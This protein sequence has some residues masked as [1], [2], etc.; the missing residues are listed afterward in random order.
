M[1]MGAVYFSA[2]AVGSLPSVVYY[3]VVPTGA[4]IVSEKLLS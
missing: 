1:L 4:W 3:T 2:S